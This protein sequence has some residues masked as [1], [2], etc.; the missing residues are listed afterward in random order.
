MVRF[1]GV[2]V[3]EDEDEVLGAADERVLLCFI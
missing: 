3:T 2:R 1:E